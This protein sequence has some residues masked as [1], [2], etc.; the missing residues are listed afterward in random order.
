MNTLY[1]TAAVAMEFEEGPPMIQR[2]RVGARSKI[3]RTQKA[4]P[5]RRITCDCLEG[6]A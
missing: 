3:G 6:K 4:A 2:R 1:T 5:S